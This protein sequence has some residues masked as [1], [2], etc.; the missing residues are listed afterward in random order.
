MKKFFAALIS[1]AMI[2]SACKKENLYTFL[3][4]VYSTSFV[5]RD[6][7]ELATAALPDT[8]LFENGEP[9]ISAYYAGI[10]GEFVHVWDTIVQYGHC[11]STTNPDPYIDPDDTTSFSAY[12]DWQLDSLGVFE[13]TLSFDPETQFFV[14][15]YIITSSGDTGYNQVVYVDTTMPP[16][17]EWFQKNNIGPFV[18]E[19][20]ASFTMYDP[21]VKHTCGY[22]VG[23]NNASEA[24]ADIWRYDPDYDVWSQLGGQLPKPI[25]EAVAFGIVTSDQYGR[26]TYRIFAGTGTDASKTERY[27]D[28][29]EYSIINSYWTRIDSFP[30]AVMSAVSFTIGDR[31]YVGT[32][33]AHYD[34][35][36]FYMFDYDRI[37]QDRSPWV[38][39]P[40]LG[41]DP[42]ANARHDAVAFVISNR[43]FVGTG[44]QVDDAENKQYYNDMWMFIPPDNNG[45]NADWTKISQFP[46]ANR[47]EAVAFSMSNQGYVGL[48]TNDETLFQDLYRYNPYN[49]EWYPIADFKEPRAYGSSQKVKN[50]FAFGI[51]K[52]GYVGGGNYS[53]SLTNY[54]WSYR[55]W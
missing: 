18:R 29:W 30:R 28:F 31:A 13:T 53:D 11:W 44:V 54:F 34:V 36:E 48:G 20:A 10:K 5:T 50:A 37:A 39:M 46:G 19:G 21:I 16:I 43:A 47:A 1:I 51:D 45:N 35:G 3:R 8:L 55:P 26:K 2:F 40:G 32:G 42:V 22:F 17:N 14:R 23:G 4:P 6:G 25:T 38:V 7:R 15:S 49:D 27:A 24:F 12:Y 33:I 41:N 52:V 9:V